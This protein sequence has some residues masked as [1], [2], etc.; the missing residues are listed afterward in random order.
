MIVVDW[1]N[2]PNLNEEIP[3][4]CWFYI[5]AVEVIIFMEEKLAIK[6]TR[7]SDGKIIN[8]QVI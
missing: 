6:E 5:E 2:E 1:L 7:I 8:G 4:F 3:K